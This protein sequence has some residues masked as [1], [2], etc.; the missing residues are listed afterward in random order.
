MFS[1][2]VSPTSHTISGGVGWTDHEIPGAPFGILAPHMLSV[3]SRNTSVSAMGVIS[4]EP[5]L[6]AQIW[7]NVPCGFAVADAIWILVRN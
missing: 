2:S 5:M 3:R 1:C 6:V 7:N 4:T